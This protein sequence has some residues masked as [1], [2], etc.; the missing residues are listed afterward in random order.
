ML[1]EQRKLPAWILRAESYRSDSVRCA[2]LERKPR[3]RTASESSEKAGPPNIICPLL[4]TK[5]ERWSKRVFN[6]N[7]PKWWRISRTTAASS[8]FQTQLSPLQTLLAQSQHYPSFQPVFTVQS[9][10]DG[11]WINDAS[12]YLRTYTTMPKRTS[13][14]LQ[15]GQ[16]AYL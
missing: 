2:Q 7:F 8:W 1:R 3:N 5:K 4:Q 13:L 16:P 15:V 10:S 6:E 9:F 12:L 14:F 11:F